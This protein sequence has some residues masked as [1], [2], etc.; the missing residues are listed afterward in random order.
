MSEWIEV[1]LV[2]RCWHRVHKVWNLT[3]RSSRFLYRVMSSK[4][5][6][7]DYADGRP[8]RIQA[9]LRGH[10]LASVASSAYFFSHVLVLTSGL[11]RFSKVLQKLRWYDP[12]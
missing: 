11:W 5:I 1:L 12:R 4:I 10:S 6:G 9:M 2:L 7:T 3:R 8:K